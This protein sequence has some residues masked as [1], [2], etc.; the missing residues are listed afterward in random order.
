MKIIIAVF[1]LAIF[2]CG[3]EEEA[4]TDPGILGTY[5]WGRLEQFVEPSIVASAGTSTGDT[6]S[7][8]GECIE[9]AAA[10]L[11]SLFTKLSQEVADSVPTYLC[12]GDAIEPG[13]VYHQ[14]PSAVIGG[15]TS[16]IPLDYYDNS[17]DNRVIY[18]ECRS[19]TKKLNKVVSY[20]FGENDSFEVD[21][22][23]RPFVHTSGDFPVMRYMIDKSYVTADQNRAIFSRIY[24]SEAIG[25][26]LQWDDNGFGESKL[27]TVYTNEFSVEELLFTN[28]GGRKDFLSN[29]MSDPITKYFD[30]D[31]FRIE[32]SDAD[33][34][35]RDHEPELELP[36]GVDDEFFSSALIEAQAD[37]E[38]E[39]VLVECPGLLSPESATN[40]DPFTQP[41]SQSD[42]CD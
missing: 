36:T 8:R 20:R 1:L 31:A 12:N 22:Q 17:E 34:S 37:C 18:K 21:T 32:E 9:P 41:T 28:V 42:S 35:V 33:Q 27:K 25:L 16:H 40:D 3:E 38:G 5:D 14:V 11:K 7:L 6:A 24:S 13:V 2:S 30:S 19:D 23:Q 4:T 39:I 29:T 10:Q 15:D 26:Q